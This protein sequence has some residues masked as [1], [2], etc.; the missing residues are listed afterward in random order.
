MIVLDRDQIAER[1]DPALAAEAIEAAYIAASAGEVQ[2]PTIGHLAFDDAGGDC[3]VKIGHRRG[4]DVFVVKIA[5]GF[6][7]NATLFPGAPVNNGASIVLSARTGEVRAVL[8]DEM[9]LTD[10]RT[11]IGAAI[12]SRTLARSDATRLLIVGTGVQADHQIHWHRALLPGLVDV[13]VWGRSAERAAAVADRNGAAVVDDLAAACA[14][15]DVIVTVTSATEPL[16]DVAMI[17]SGTHI[18]AV[19]ADAPGKHELTEALLDRADVVVADRRSQC[20]DH[21]ECSVLSPA[22]PIREL[23][24]V[25]AGTEPGRDD[26]AQ[27]TIADLTGIAAQDVAI[28][29]VVLAAGD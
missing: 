19:G 16:I 18:T 28:A 9:T 3:H 25:L 7:G 21:G 24:A 4:D 17:T 29:G 6:P 13:A 22:T 2:L 15:A 8:H 26:D 11:A 5:T 23:G 10:V 27:V 14:S 12:A 20:L 1:L